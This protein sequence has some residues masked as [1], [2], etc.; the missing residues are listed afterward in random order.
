MFL[1]A[2]ELCKTDRNNTGCV[3]LFVYQKL[4]WHWHIPN[5]TTVF[6]QFALNELMVSAGVP[7]AQQFI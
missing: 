1:F 7:T 4:L 3:L 5:I 6:T 2:A